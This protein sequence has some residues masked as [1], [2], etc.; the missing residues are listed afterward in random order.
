MEWWELL[1]NK[2]AGMGLRDLER[3][4]RGRPVVRRRREVARERRRRP[5][6]R[7]QNHLVAQVLGEDMTERIEWFE[8]D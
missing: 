2:P 7:P 3:R 6:D 8:Q 1:W 4:G 5:R